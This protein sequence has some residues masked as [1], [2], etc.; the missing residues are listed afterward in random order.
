[1]SDYEK[2]PTVSTITSLPPPP[3]SE[4]VVVV[5]EAP[6]DTLPVTGGDVAGLALIAVVAV[7]SGVAMVRGSRR[8]A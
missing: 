8:R 7:A 5:R 4:T 1:M 3:P 2:T 6:P